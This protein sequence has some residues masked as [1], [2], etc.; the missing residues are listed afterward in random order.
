MARTKEFDQDQ[1]VKAAMELF[2]KKGFTATSIQDLEEATGVLRTSIYNAF[3]NKRTL[4]KICLSR[5]LRQIE[6][7]LT[8]IVAEAPTAREAVA[9]W[10]A[11]VIR[12]LTDPQTP[13]GCLVVFSVFEG[14]QHDPETRAMAAGL[15]AKERRAVTALLEAGV[16]RGEFPPSLDCAEVAGA[17]SAATWGLVVLAAAGTGAEQLGASAR[18]TLRLLD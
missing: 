7:S 9:S 17:I 4:F 5:Y 13:A 1:A 18:V 8:G 10:H 6:E 12:I 16:M 14:E 15:F 2:W 11:R 3:G